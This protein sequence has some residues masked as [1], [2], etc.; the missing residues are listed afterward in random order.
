[1]P[2]FLEIDQLGKTL[3]DA[4]RARRDRPGLHLH[5]TE[6]EFV[7]VIGHS[8]CGKSTVLSIVMGLNDADHRRCGDRGP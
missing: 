1:M 4:D 3:P 8:G 2:A 7:C 6:G 5:V